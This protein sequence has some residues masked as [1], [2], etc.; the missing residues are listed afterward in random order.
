MKNTHLI[1][2]LFLMAFF[3]C[4]EVEKKEAVTIG[5]EV[6]NLSTVE[7][8]KRFLENILEDD[9]KV[10]GSEGQALMLKYGEG[11]EEYMNYIKAQWKQDEINLYKVEQYLEK[12]GYPEKDL[13][14]QK[15]VTAPWMVIHHAQGYDVRERNFE[16][17]YGAYLK[18]DIDDT[19]MSFYL[20]RMYEKKNRERFR[21]ESPYRAEDEINQLVKELNLEAQQANVRQLVKRK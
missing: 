5:N 6:E 17:V 16:K 7:D 19:A 20:G 1:L 2:F 4:R 15:A 14:G 21:M 18:E 3:G 9:Q 8:K 12:F 11:S 10:R 13:M